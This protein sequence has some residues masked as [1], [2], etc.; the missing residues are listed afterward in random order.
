[1][2]VVIETSN[3]ISNSISFRLYMFSHKIPTFYHWKAPARVSFNDVPSDRSQF[4]LSN[5]GDSF[6]PT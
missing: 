3:F 6:G 4:E 1:M 5:L 2:R